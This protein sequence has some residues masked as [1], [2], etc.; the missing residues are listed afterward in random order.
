[1]QEDS[2]S[3]TLTD[4]EFKETIKNGKKK[5]G[6]TQ[7]LQPCPCKTCKKNKYGEDPVA[8]THD[9][10]SKFTC[11][12]D[13]QWI[14][15]NGVWKNLYRNI[16]EDH[17]AGKRRQFTTTLPILGHKFIPMPQAMKIPAAKAAVD[18]NGRNWKRIPAWD[19]KSQGTNLNW[20]MK[21]EK[22][23]E[24]DISHHRWTSVIWRMPN[25][26]PKHQKLQRSRCTTRGHFDKMILVSYAVF[27]EQGSSASQMTAAKVMAIISRLPGCAGQA[28]DA[29]ISLYPSENGRCSKIIENS[30]IGMSR[31]MDS[32]TTTQMA[33]IIVQH[34]RSSR[35]SW[36]KSVW[37]SF[38]RTIYEK[39]QFEKVLLK[40]GWEKVSNGECLF[41]HREKGSF[42][43]VHV[44]AHLIGWK[45]RKY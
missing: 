13:S 41:V 7:R 1:M 44:D 45:E 30:Q 38:C 23:V 20:L 27:T 37:S 26:R 5:I 33:K 32:S 31:H 8:K 12:L 40:Y 17:I 43:S 34:G 18:K 10:K 29:C 16:I 14:H 28:A 9:F 3:L 35:S 36:T 2:I 19:N 24:K 11:I 25:W 39:G 22:K 4:K 6:N 15:K 42:L 21:R